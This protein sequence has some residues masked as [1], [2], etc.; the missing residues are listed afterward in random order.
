MKRILTPLAAFGL[1]AGLCLAVPT[2]ARAQ[3]ALIE[4]ALRALFATCKDIAN[5]TQKDECV[6]RAEAKSKLGQGKPADQAAAGTTNKAKAMG[7]KKRKR[8]N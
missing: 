7:E 8:R 1:M 5:P 3:E 2:Q 4:E 6:S